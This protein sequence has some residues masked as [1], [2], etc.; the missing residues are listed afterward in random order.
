MASMNRVR[1][2]AGL[3]LTDFTERYG[4]Q[5]QCEPALE[6]YRWRDGFVC[7]MCART[8]HYV[9]WHGE[10]KTFQWH[11]CRHQTTLTSGT[12]FHTSKLPLTK[13]FQAMWYLTESKNNVSALELMRV[14]GVC[15]R[16]TWRL[17]HKIL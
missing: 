10:A 3:S 8:D 11:S 17:K 7:P 13:W 4:T 16:T 5:A 2:Q 9:V 15:Y 6:K 1:F 12:I 14:V